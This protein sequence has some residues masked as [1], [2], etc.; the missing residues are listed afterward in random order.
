MDKKQLNATPTNS[1]DYQLLEETKKLRT[2]KSTLYVSKKD[3][4]EDASSTAYIFSLFGIIGDILTLLSLLGI[5]SLP[6]ASSLLSQIFMLI[7]FTVFLIIGINSWRKATILKSEIGEEEDTTEQVNSWLET[8]IPKN[9]LDEISDS[10]VSEEIDY[11]NK[12]NY[13]KE[14]LQHQFPN[15]DIDYLDA[16]ADAY[17]TKLLDTIE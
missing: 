2:A 14:Q 10:S 4:W 9:V 5:V 3:R 6:F 15:I 13:L 7:L 17:L 1:Q 11:F 16:L 8:Q 12:L